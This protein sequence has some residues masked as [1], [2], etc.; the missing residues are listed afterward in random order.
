MATSVPRHPYPTDNAVEGVAVLNETV[1]WILDR[2]ERSEVAR[3]QALSTTV[4][5]AKSRCALDPLAGKI[6][7]WEAWVVAMQTGS[8]LFAAATAEEGGVQCRIG[9]ETRTIPAIG[10][11]SY[12][13]AGNWVSSFYLALVC[14]EQG[15]LNQLARV[16]ISLLRESG[17]MYDEYI[18]AWVDSLQ[19]YWL[20]ESGVMEKL[21]EAVDGASPQ[22]AQVADG[23]QLL[24][25]LYPP[26]ELFHRYL[27]QEHE[28]FNEALVDALTWHKEYWTGDDDRA[29]SSAG[30]VA[31]GP[32]AL[33]CLAREAGFPIEVES[34]YLPKALLEYAWAGELET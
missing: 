32:L 17:A 9:G 11:R 3:A 6:E 10:P 8:A 33:A 16:P 25:I 2:L 29:M 15:R 31:L 20:G 5:L 21:V 34:E 19:R 23:E 26:L 24:K 13:D 27:T 12:T 28:K 30:L 14:R 7:S 18:Y 1:D 4:T 22:V